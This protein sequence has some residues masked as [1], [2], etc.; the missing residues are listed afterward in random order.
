LRA[1]AVACAAALAGCAA[2]RAEPPV[3]ATLSAVENALREGRIEQAKDAV[4]RARARQPMDVD[5]AQ[6]SSVVASLLWDDER[7]VQ[8]QNAALRNG[9]AANIAPELDAAMRG[10]LGDL[11]FHAGR[12]GEATVP[13]LAGATGADEE[14]RRAFAAIAR[15][16]PFVRKPAGPLQTEQPL[17]PG[18]VPEF[19][20]GSGARARPFAIDTG[21]SMTTLGRSFAEELGVRARARA[22]SA[23]DGAGRRLPVEVGLLD[24]FVVGDVQIGAVPVLI[25]DD[26]ALA[27]RDLFGGAERSPQGVLGLDLLA[28]F[29]LTLDPERR[30]VVLELPRG[31][32]ETGSV[33]CV[34]SDGRCLLPVAVEGVRLWFVLDTGASH[35]SLTDSGVRALPGGE[36]R[37]VPSFRRVRTVGGALVA[38]REV[39]DLV[40]RASAARFAGVDLPVVPRG[41]SPL[42]PVNGVLG[43]DLLSH[44]RVTFD[45]GRARLTALQ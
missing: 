40:L 30:N 32:T 16:L 35:S 19:I 18:D 5:V 33:Q 41:E 2:R 13:L 29:R 38:V 22:G 36:G 25:V 14:R 9:R 34:R 39:R 7:A 31:L 10:R 12:W 28:S 15:L 37:A 3:E 1:L 24:G 8:E 4:E 11:L 42:F 20:C 44:C 23:V 26:G 6:W 43:I 17:L 27:L 45:R 21:S